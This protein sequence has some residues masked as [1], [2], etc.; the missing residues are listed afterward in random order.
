M[1]EM[2]ANKNIKQMEKAEKILSEV[3]NELQPSANTTREIEWDTCIEAMKRFAKIKCRE[4]REIC[5]KV[6]SISYRIE[7][8]EDDE[9]HRDD[10]LNAEEP[11]F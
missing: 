4:Q 6:D 7:T 11:I 10:V 5:S 8:S 1:I 3:I 9:E 2:R